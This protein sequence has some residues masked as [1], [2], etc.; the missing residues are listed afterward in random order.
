MHQSDLYLPPVNSRFAPSARLPAPG[1]SSS[2]WPESFSIAANPKKRKVERACDGCRRRKTRCD[3]PKMPDNVCT[4]CVQNRKICTYV[5]ASKPRGPPKAYITSLENRMEKMEALLKRLRPETDFSTELGPPILRGSWKNEP[6]N[7]TSTPAGG[8]T[9]P[10]TL[11]QFHRLSTLAPLALSRKTSSTSLSAMSDHEGNIPSDDPDDPTDQ[12]IRK[13]QR[14]TLLDKKTK[15]KA[16]RKLDSA[17][18]FHGKSTNFNLVM[19]TRDMRTR[20]LMESMGAAVDTITN[21]A[22]CSQANPN[23]YTLDMKGRSRQEYWR[24]PDWELVYEGEGEF[25]SPETFSEFLQSWPP[26]DLATA[27]I[28][29]YFLHCN[30]MFPLLHRPTFARHFAD[31]LYEKDIWFACLCMSVFALASRYTDDLRV[32][33]DEPV[34]TSV[35]EHSEQS[36][37]QTA[38]FKYYFSPTTEVENKKWAILNAASLFEIQTLCLTTQFQS[39]TRWHRGIW[40]TIGVGIRKV[41]DMGAHSKKSYGKGGPTVENELWKRVWWYLIGLDRMQCAILGRPCAVKEEDFTAEFPLEVDDDFWENDDPQRSFRQPPDR[42][43]TVTAFNL[44]LQLT[45]FA[46]SALHCFVS[47]HDGPS[48]GLRAEGILD[49]L[50][51]NLTVWAEKVPQY[52]R[53]S[54]DIEDVALANQSATLYTTYNLVTILIRRA[55]L[56]SSVELLSSSNDT[57]PIPPVLAH[58]MTA[59]AIS[60]NAAK[61]IAR[62]LTVVPKRS[63]SNIPL[64][65]T[66]AEITITV[67]CIDQWIIKARDDKLVSSATQTIESHMQDIKSLLTALRWAAPRWETAQEKL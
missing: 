46:A 55:F 26:S 61:A 58:A 31:K 6:V 5:E 8:E 47:H 24:S 64:L 29:L 56:P 21:E 40:Y 14:L 1:S 42:P 66:G 20:Y 25:L 15:D 2:D 53:W 51:E 28:E 23:Q 27:L 48:S 13:T 49:Q 60:I 19:A 45:D 44:W 57:R 38:G 33:M 52:L 65:L 50:N 32:L 4:N 10:R 41:Q 22:E 37:W 12:L 43:S 7:P 18:R 3:G 16:N 34:E 35:G 59:R 17:I 30:S 54:P 62:I 39:E 9:S 11:H 67:L 63:L 36:R